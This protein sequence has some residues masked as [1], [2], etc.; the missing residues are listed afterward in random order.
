LQPRALWEFPVRLLGLAAVGGATAFAFTGVFAIATAVT[1]LAAAL[2]FA[3]VFSFAGVGACLLLRQGLERD[4]GLRGC[5]GC[6][7]ANRQRSGHEPATAAL[8]MSAFDVF[9]RLL[10]SC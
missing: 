5:I 8:A 9:I 4:S 10:I 1:S 7:G 6:V 2:T 3:G